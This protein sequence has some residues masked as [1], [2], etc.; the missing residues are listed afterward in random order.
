LALDDTKWWHDHGSFTV[1]ERAVRLHVRL[2]KVHPFPNGN[3]R[4]TRLVADLYLVSIGAE[5]FGWG[6][7]P[8][9]TLAG[10]ARTVYIE[11]LRSADEDDFGPLVRFARG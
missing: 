5:P 11:A 3:G 8:D 2:V 4:C 7:R 6:T 1:D 10:D 9:L